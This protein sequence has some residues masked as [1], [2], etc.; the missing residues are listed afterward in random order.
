MKA[1]ACIGVAVIVFASLL[2]AFAGKSYFAAKCPTDD[3]VIAWFHAN[4]KTLDDLLNMVTAD[5]EKVTYVGQGV[6]RLRPGTAL[7]EAKIQEYLRKVH[8][9]GADSF[10]YTRNEGATIMLWSD[11]PS[12]I[13]AITGSYRYKD[14]AYIQDRNKG[15]YSERL[16]PNLN[17]LEKSSEDGVWLRHLEGNWYIVYAK[18]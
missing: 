13:A 17:G 5:D 16:R 12:T 4:K 15:R 6:V 14:V 7:P 9:T 3:A 10:N 11:V 1:A 2:L 8:E 18:H